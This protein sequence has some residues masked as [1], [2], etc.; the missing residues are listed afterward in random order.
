MVPVETGFGG[1]MLPDV[2]AGGFTVSAGIVL[3]AAPWFKG[4]RLTTSV[5]VDFF[6]RTPLSLPSGAMKKTPKKT[7]DTTTRPMKRTI[8]MR[9]MASSMNSVRDIGIEPVP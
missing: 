4:G 9:R 8:M 5:V 2:F 7:I 1:G 3:L 6:P